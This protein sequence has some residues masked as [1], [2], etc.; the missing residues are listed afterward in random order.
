MAIFKHFLFLLAASM[1]VWAQ[2]APSE[3]PDDSAARCPAFPRELP[4]EPNARLPDPFTFLN[5]KKVDSQRDWACRREEIIKILETYETGSL[6]PKARFVKGS[7]DEDKFNITASHEGKTVS[8]VATIRYPEKGRA[9]FPAIIGIGGA[10]IPIPDDIAFITFPNDLV[11]QQNGVGSRGKGLFYDL[12]GADHPASALTAW[13]WGVSTLLD[14][15]ESTRG[16]R[17][18]ERK[19]G[20]TGCSRNGKGAFTIGALEP[21]IALTIPQESGTDKEKEEGVNVQTATQIITENVWFSPVF[22]KYVSQVNSLP[23]DHHLLAGLYA[24]RGLF[25]LDHAGIDWLGPTSTYGCMVAGRKIF[26]SLGVARN[27]GIAQTTGHSHCQFPER[28]TPKVDAFIDKFLR[29]NRRANTTIVSTEA[30]NNAGFVEKD[31]IDWRVPRL[32]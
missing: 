23:Y 5:G 28:L 18:D 6:P 7:L 10:T 31:W 21:R 11:A 16:T 2:D 30:P 26:Q 13:G 12:Y 20:L 17:I 27:M 8:F 22:D 1:S 9:P 3:D 4:S 19:I 14:A 25:I 29:G 15:L 32:D 24:P